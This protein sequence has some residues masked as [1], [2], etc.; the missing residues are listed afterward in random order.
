LLRHEGLLS[1]ILT[2]LQSETSDTRPVTEPLAE[3]LAKL[4]QGD[5]TAEKIAGVITPAAHSDLTCSAD[6]EYF[7]HIVKTIVDSE[8][9][10]MFAGLS[11]DLV[12]MM[13]FIRYFMQIAAAS[14]KMG[15]PT[16]SWSREFQESML[17]A[18]RIYTGQNAG[19]E[20]RSVSESTAFRLAH[21]IFQRQLPVSTTYRSRNCCG[22][23]KNGL[24]SWTP[25]G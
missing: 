19:N 11:D 4:A 24:T 14:E 2:D 10:K 3:F 20:H 15:I 21:Q 12:S 25:S 16:C 23:V 18:R 22:Y 1:P 8:Y 5:E 13:Y 17:V 9:L 7:N 6:D